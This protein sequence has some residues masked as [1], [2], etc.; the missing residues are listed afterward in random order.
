MNKKDYIM[1]LL[2]PIFVVALTTFVSATVVLTILY[3]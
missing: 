2:I 3:L 1:G